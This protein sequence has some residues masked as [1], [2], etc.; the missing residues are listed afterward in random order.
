MRILI[1]VFF[2]QLLLLS[3]GCKK[4]ENNPSGEQTVLLTFTVS[5]NFIAKD[6]AALS[7]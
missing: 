5:G 4:K 1:L 3:G 2:I 6:L 7:F